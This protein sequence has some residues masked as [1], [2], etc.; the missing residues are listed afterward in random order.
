MSQTSCISL[1]LFLF[2]FIVKSFLLGFLI[3]P[4]LPGGAI[5]DTCVNA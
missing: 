3:S 5:K 2:D 1:E 4:T